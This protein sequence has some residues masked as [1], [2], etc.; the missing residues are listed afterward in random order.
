M[1]MEDIDHGV[2][3]FQGIRALGVHITLD[4]FGTG[5]S[6][7]AYLTRLPLDVLKIDRS[8]IHDMTLGP[9]GVSVVSNIIKLAH[10]LNLRVVA[11]GIETQEQAR[12]LG[13]LDCDEVQGFLYSEPVPRDVLEDRFMP[14]PT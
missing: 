5:F 3:T 12:L 10:S 9:N 11:E 4:D 1:L 13:I 2:K 6:S 8:F 14:V 7:L